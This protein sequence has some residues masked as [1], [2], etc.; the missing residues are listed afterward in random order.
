MFNESV[1][2]FRLFLGLCGA[3]FHA[4]RRAA[5]LS[6]ISRVAGRSRASAHVIPPVEYRRHRRL[7]NARPILGTGSIGRVEITSRRD[8][9]RWPCK[10]NYTVRG[11]LRPSTRLLAYKRETEVYN[12]HPEEKPRYGADVINSAGCAGYIFIGHLSVT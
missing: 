12:G 7:S 9:S 10:T 1:L 3:A 5:G 4:H 2:R 8:E 6:T 11:M